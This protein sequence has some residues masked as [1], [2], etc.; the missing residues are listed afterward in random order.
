[1]RRRRSRVRA[2]GGAPA[3]IHSGRL[4]FA[5]DPGFAD[6]QV[7]VHYREIRLH[8]GS[9]PSAACADAEQPRGITRRQQDRDADATLRAELK[10]RSGTHDLCLFFT[11]RSPTFLRAIEWV[12]PVLR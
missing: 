7:F 9:D 6:H 5:G 2:G 1:M 12:S 3:L 10:P 11:G 4:A 8:A